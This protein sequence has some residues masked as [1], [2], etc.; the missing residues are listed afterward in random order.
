[1]LGKVWGLSDRSGHFI[2]SDLFN[3]N[4]SLDLQAVKI[5]NRI[6]GAKYA[7]IKQRKS[8]FFQV[9]VLAS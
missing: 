2:H 3:R 4:L 9:L 6:V 7:A 5:V 8:C 1:M